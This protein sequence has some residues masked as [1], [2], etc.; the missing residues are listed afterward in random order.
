MHGKLKD[1]ESISS[2]DVSSCV[3]PPV[4]SIIES[5]TYWCLTSL[6]STIQDHYTPNQPGLQRQ[7][8]TLGSVVKRTDARLHTHLQDLG[9]EYIQFAFKW[10]NCLLV[11]E[12][13]PRTVAR[14]WDTY[15]SEEGGFSNFHVY[16]CAA[17]LTRFSA[18]LRAK[19][20]F[21]DLFTTLQQGLPT[22]EWSDDDVSML[23]S[24]AFVLKSLF[25]GSEKHLE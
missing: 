8:H 2:L 22:E 24:Q 5:D 9:V 18:E 10:C 3:P 14:L 21:G 16:A 17:L 4:L 7:V 11:R 25:E 13:Q 20:D 23:C 1:N 12:F 15:L 19:V 6:L